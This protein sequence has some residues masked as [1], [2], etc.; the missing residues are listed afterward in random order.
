MEENNVQNG[1]IKVNI[2]SNQTTI[3][4]DIDGHG[5]VRI[6]GT[7]LG[8]IK[9]SGKIVIGKN[10][11]IEGDIDCKDLVINGQVEGTVRVKG[12]LSLTASAKLY[13]DMIIQQLSVEAGA[14]LI[15]HCNVNNDYSITND[16]SNLK[17]YLWPKK[18]QT[19]NP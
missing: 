12:L 17:K 9:A 8:N 3:T 14:F 7:L 19:P 2:I 18:Y 13:G 10:G 4:G 6:D 11:K 16:E 15:G 1:S 5:N